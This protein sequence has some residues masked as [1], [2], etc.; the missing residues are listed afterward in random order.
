MTYVYNAILVHQAFN[1]LERSDD[2][3][4]QNQQCNVDIVVHLQLMFTSESISVTAQPAASATG[5]QRCQRNF[6]QDKIE[7][8]RSLMLHGRHIQ[9]DKDKLQQGLS[10]NIVITFV[11][12]R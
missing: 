4:L 9:H 10:P 8:Q 12:I 3:Q 5:F 11:K 7:Y 6:V 2:E 1:N